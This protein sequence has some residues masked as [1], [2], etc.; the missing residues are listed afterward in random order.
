MNY[1][2]DNDSTN[3]P[4][5]TN[6]PY[7]K[8]PCQSAYGTNPTLAPYCHIHQQTDSAAMPAITILIALIRQRFTDRIIVPIRLQLTDRLIGKLYTWPLSLPPLVPY[9]HLNRLLLPVIYQS[10]DRRACTRSLL[11]PSLVPYYHLDRPLL[12]LQLILI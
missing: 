1:E 12:C 9:Y 7:D 6:P 2:L 10:T 8:T 3:T 4:T 11:L 5:I